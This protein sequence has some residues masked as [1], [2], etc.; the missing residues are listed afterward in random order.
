VNNLK[1][2]IVGSNGIV[3]SEVHTALQNYSADIK[4]VSRTDKAGKQVHKADLTDAKQTINAVKGYDVIYLTVGITYSAELWAKYWPGI[5]DNVINA[6]LETGARLVF[7][8]NVYMY[9]KVEGWMTENTPFNPVTKKGEVRARLAEKILDAIKYRGLTALIARSADFYGYTDQSIPNLLV[10]D[11]LSRNENP[12]VL[13]N[14][15]K[16]HTFT[17]V[18]DIGKSIAF[19]AQDKDNFNQTWH[20]PTDNNALSSGEYARL[21]SAAFGKEL[22]FDILGKEALDTIAQTNAIIG[23]Y[24]EMLYQNEYD[25]LFSSRKY[26]EAFKQ[27]ATPY[28][29]GIQE[30]ANLYL[31]K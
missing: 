24:R 22:S 10:F 2:V 3:G 26:E 27:F 21:V 30:L 16:K 18:K 11:R 17:Y 20:L 28:H 29:A 13:L 7:L 25:Y 15:D 9:G 31:N 5:V 4:L 19:L 6:A 14:S 1:H 12:L 8:D 23:E